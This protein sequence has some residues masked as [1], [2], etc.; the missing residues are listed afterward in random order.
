MVQYR[1]VILCAC[2]EVMEGVNSGSRKKSTATHITRPLH[3]TKRPCTN[4]SH[5]TQTTIIHR[6]AQP[7]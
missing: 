4:T 3:S 1:A 7:P 6:T 2:V 5:D